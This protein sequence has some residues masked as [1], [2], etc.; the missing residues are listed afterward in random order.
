MPWKPKHRELVLTMWPTGCG[1]ARIIEALAAEHGIHVSKSAVVGI[2]FRAGLAFCGAR[3]KPPP[4]R[5]PRPP[6]VA[7][8][9]EQR[10]ERERARAA[11]RRERAAAD[12]GRP[13]PPPRPRVAAAGVPESLRIPIWEIRDGACRYIADDPRE[14]GTCCGHQTFPG[15]PWCEGHRAECVAQPGR[16]VSTWVRFRRVA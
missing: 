1:S 15:S 13:V 2:A 8:T 7:M 14:G 11:R 10:A 16:Q 3:K 12:A 4:P 6:R 5:G 9:P